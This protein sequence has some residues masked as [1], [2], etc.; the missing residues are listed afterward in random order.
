M[1]RLLVFTLLSA[2]IGS[3]CGGRSSDFTAL[4]CAD[5]EADVWRATTAAIA[6]GDTDPEVNVDRSIEVLFEQMATIPSECDEFRDEPGYQALWLSQLSFS[7]QQ[8]YR[9]FVVAQASE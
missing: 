1:R 8:M 9:L 2:L 7:E 4:S 5:S 3:A 6:N